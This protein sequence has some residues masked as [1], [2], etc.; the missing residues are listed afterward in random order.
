VGVGGGGYGPAADTLS[1]WGGEEFGR[2][3]AGKV[4][5]GGGGHGLDWAAQGSQ[6]HRALSPLQVSV[7]RLV[8]A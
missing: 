6:T 2:E 8:W 4:G 7:G 1:V 3:G 5:T